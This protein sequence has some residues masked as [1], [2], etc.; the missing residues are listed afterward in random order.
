MD[1]TFLN[2]IM[3]YVIIVAEIIIG[4]AIIIS[5]IGW[6]V[7]DQTNNVDRKRKSGLAFLISVSLFYI[8]RFG[9]IAVL[10]LLFSKG[11][12]PGM[13]EKSLVYLL[14]ILQ[15]LILALVPTFSIIQHYIYRYQYLIIEREESR[16]RQRLYFYVAFAMTAGIVGLLEIMIGLVK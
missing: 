1:S 13:E 7:G 11:S 15:V 4:L 12:L 8:F 16:Q 10:A 9:S 2:H 6:V 5:G 14:R 3:Y